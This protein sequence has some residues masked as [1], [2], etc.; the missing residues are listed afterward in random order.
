MTSTLVSNEEE[1]NGQL[2]SGRYRVIRAL[3]EGG[4]GKV[5]LAEHEAI[6]KR[7]ALKVLHREY[8]ANPDVVERFKQEAISASRIKHP[9]VIDIFDFGQLDDGSCFIAMELL[10][11][12]DLGD[13]LQQRGVFSP[14]QAVQIA[15]QICRALQTAHARG[16][17]HRDMK[18]EN[19]FLQTTPDGE[20]NVKIVDFGIAQLRK[21]EDT[22]APAP[23]RRRLT[24]TGMIFG[25]PEY[26]A[27]E[28]ARGQGIDHRSDI[29]ATGIILYELV[30]GSVP[31]MGQSLLEVL[32]HHVLSPVPP[33]RHKY[34]QIQI[35]AELE[36]LI[37]Q[38]LE[39]RPEDRFESMKALAE[40]LVQTPE[41]A[42][43]GRHSLVSL[44]SLTDAPQ[45][46][47]SPAPLDASTQIHGSPRGTTPIVGAQTI[48]E[49]PAGVPQRSW[50]PLISV[51]GFAL[52]G[53]IG[54]AVWK[55]L[56]GPSPEE[57]PASSDAPVAPERAVAAAPEGQNL[58]PA[59]EPAVA[60]AAQEK[61][62]APEQIV[63]SVVTVPPGA[64]IEK[65]GFQ[66]CESSPCEVLAE[67]DEA[68]TLTARL[69]QRVGTAKVLAQR[70]Q[71]VSI[72]LSAPPARKPKPSEN[73]APPQ[74]QLCE[75]N[76]D[77][78]KIL[79]P[80]P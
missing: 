65:E 56:S 4:M 53:M 39:K 30:S 10:E 73:K 72:T 70:D 21:A 47:V 22:D 77:G 50:T 66:V 71:N 45:T 9:N 28:Q 24:K 67:R 11:G 27:P 59:P 74:Q 16:V 19:V 75:V 64:L 58:A 80:C 52:V 26:M 17:V 31:F 29:Y 18:P 14:E 7:I 62:A 68:L 23:G 57:K 55:N 76:V 43:L 69:G 48:P 37:Y 33:L 78:L 36:A 35:S 25:T 32:N 2:V 42:A 1:L 46:Q 41:G 3:G 51:L 6:E 20:Q 13:A 54:F 79:R 63:L 40:A 61:P 15:L 38:A 12:Q 44:T 8:S 5:Y 49:L 60:P 34:P